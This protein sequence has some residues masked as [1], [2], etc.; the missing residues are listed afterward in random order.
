M[1]KLLLVY[2]LVLLWVLPAKSTFS[3][4][5]FPQQ[6]RYVLSLA[7]QSPTSAWDGQVSITACDEIILLVPSR[8]KISLCTIS[9]SMGYGGFWQKYALLPMFS[10]T[11]GYLVQTNNHA[12]LLLS[13]AAKQQAIGYEY[14]METVELSALAW[15][16]RKEDPLSFQTVW[17]SQHARWGV[18]GKVFLETSLLDV[19]SELLF[20][21][22]KGMEACFAS[23]L[24]GGSSKLEFAYGEDPY[25]VRYSLSLALSNKAL[26][27]SFVMEDWFGSKPI[28]GGFSAMRKR[29]QTSVVRFSLGK[30]YLSVSF[31]DL[32]EFKPKG[33]E[34][35]SVVM[36]VTYAFPFGQISA[37]YVGDRDPLITD[38][39]QYKLTLVVYKAALSYTE[40]G[41]EITLTDS[42]VLGKGIGTWKL[43]KSKANAVSF[44]LLYSIGSV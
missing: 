37:E 44:S 35:G 1:R 14:T 42:F 31:S 30:G 20:T 3:L 16:Q 11:R 2:I 23:T 9:L 4:A 39:G 5:M 15:L 6:R 38:A 40:Q 32:Y 21:P 28:Y 8:F 34:M 27:I 36:Q 17:G 25:P 18:A 13:E 33:D 22:V 43:K 10:G 7:K 24:K 19:K 26:Q 41:Y 29:R 12:L